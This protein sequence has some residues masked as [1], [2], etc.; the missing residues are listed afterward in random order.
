MA[1]RILT[2]GDIRVTNFTAPPQNSQQLPCCSFELGMARVST[3]TVSTMSDGPSIDTVFG[4]HGSLYIAF[5]P[6]AQGSAH[7]RVHLYSG[8]VPRPGNIMGLGSVSLV[9]AVQAGAVSV[10]LLDRFGQDAG[11]VEFAVQSDAPA[12]APRSAANHLQAADSTAAHALP[13]AEK[14]QAQPMDDTLPITPP[15]IQTNRMVPSSRSSTAGSDNGDIPVTF[16]QNRL[17]NV[18][19]QESYERG[20]FNNGVATPAF[21]D[22][23]G[24]SRHVSEST[25]REDPWARSMTDKAKIAAAGAMNNVR[26]AI[27]SAKRIGFNG[28]TGSNYGKDSRSGNHMYNRHQQ[29]LGHSPNQTW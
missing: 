18:T 1:P 21:Q 7:L 13:T 25:S 24:N 27:D 26:T 8:N 12:E 22:S 23:Y 2:I 20:T 5:D 6:Q 15:Q 28:N 10:H 17:G 9:A 19:T 11:D 29:Y 16:T 4:K 14:G 3:T